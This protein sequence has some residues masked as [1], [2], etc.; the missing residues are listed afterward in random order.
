MVRIQTLDSTG[1]SS[2]DPEN[3]Q[4]QID[5]IP[6]PSDIEGIYMIKGMH[7]FTIRQ[8]GQPEYDTTEMIAQRNET[9]SLVSPW[10]PID[11][12]ANADDLFVSINNSSKRLLPYRFFLPVGNHEAIFS[13]SRGDIRE[14][15][16]IHV[17]GGTGASEELGV[18]AG[19]LKIKVLPVR[20]GLK[21]IVNGITHSLNQGQ[22]DLSLSTGEQRIQLFIDEQLVYEANLALRLGEVI[23]RTINLTPAR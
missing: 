12:D 10:V 3:Y 15:R 8:Q 20:S 11:F 21:L 19:I 4:L 7:R 6:V 1:K 2:L 13:D 14:S 18:S 17:E 22:R 9:I 16:R 23:E 5:R